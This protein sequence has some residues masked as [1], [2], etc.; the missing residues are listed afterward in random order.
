MSLLEKVKHLLSKSLFWALGVG[1][2]ALSIHALDTPAQTTP[3]NV[4]EA[5]VKITN[6]AQNSGGS[7]SVVSISDTESEILTNSHVCELLKVGGK[8]TTTYG[9]TH[10]VKAYR[11]D[12]DHDLCLV[13]VPA[14]LKTKS[15]IASSKP[16]LYSAAA[17]SGHPN[18][19]PNVITR[20]HFTENQ[21]IQVF[22]GIDK[23]SEEDAA[24]PSLG[25]V[26]FFFGGLPLVSSGS[27]VYDS[28]GHIG[29]VAFAGSS[30]MSYAFV[31]PYEYVSSFLNKNLNGKNR[32]QFSKPDYKV[33]I[34]A[35]LQ[36]E[37]LRNKTLIK[38]CLDTPNNIII[39]D[40]CRV[41]T[42]TLS[43]R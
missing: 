12:T 5:T 18:L 24:D 32:E 23:C 17:I 15:N 38:K 7:G 10:V 39:E 22:I 43:W 30:G 29:G 19:L 21:F 33:N 26:C 13:V 9:E 41:I 2:L 1:A 27:A 35:L 14:K 25:M 4:T 31:V 40:M 3:L 42:E 37:N 8:V 16:E 28:T 11:Q 20:G 34:K 6:M 36:K